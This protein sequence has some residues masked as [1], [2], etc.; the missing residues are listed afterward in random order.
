MKPASDAAAEDRVTLE[1]R[2]LKLVRAIVVDGGVT[3][4]RRAAARVAAGPLPAAWPTWKRRLGALLF[5]RVGRRMV[6]TPAAERL[7]Q[8]ADT[9]LGELARAG[10]GG[11]RLRPRPQRR[12]PD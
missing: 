7:I 1:V 10:G 8:T 9:V 12:D 2:H 3:C 5:S 4:A 11:A 6:A